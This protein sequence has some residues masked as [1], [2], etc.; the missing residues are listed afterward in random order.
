MEGLSYD[1][2]SSM[3]GKSELILQMLV[4]LLMGDGMMKKIILNASRLL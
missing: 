3:T 4:N 1:S 2:P